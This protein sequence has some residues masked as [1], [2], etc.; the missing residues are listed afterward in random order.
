MNPNQDNKNNKGGQGPKKRGFFVGALVW[1]LVLVI[2]FN[3]IA[4]E[5]ANAGTKEVTYS[6]FIQM[7]ES[8]ELRRSMSRGETA[9]TMRPRRDSSGT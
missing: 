1:A 2:I 5:I 4:G 9:G 3:F 8:R 6:E 7:V